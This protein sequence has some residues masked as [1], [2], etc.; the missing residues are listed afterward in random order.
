MANGLSVKRQ[1]FA[2]HYVKTHGNGAE[3]ARRAGYAD[4]GASSPRTEA[5]RVLAD[6]GVQKRIAEIKAMS[7]DAND[8]TA[9]YIA[10]A[11]HWE[12]LNAESDGARAMMWKTLA[13]W[14]AMLKEVFK[15][16]EPSDAELAAKARSL[17]T[18]EGEAIAKLLESS[19]PEVD[20]GADKP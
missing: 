13:Q 10:K 5:V 7:M 18:A 20:Q 9:E 17:G 6:A 8:I 1:A 4:N 14:R 15:Q 3:S 12:A 2:E 11:I 19:S 16:E